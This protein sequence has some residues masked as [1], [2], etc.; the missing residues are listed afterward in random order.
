MQ[1]AKGPTCFDTD[2]CLAAVIELWY[3]L[4]YRSWK[5]NELLVQGKLMMTDN[6]TTMS[7]VKSPLAI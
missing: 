5:L 7:K 6:R 3:L 1:F 4:G 2:L